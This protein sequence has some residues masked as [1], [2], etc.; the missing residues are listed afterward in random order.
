M[1]IRQLYNSL[2]P[3]DRAIY[4]SIRTDMRKIYL[5]AHTNIVGMDHWDNGDDAWLDLIDIKL[6]TLFDRAG[7]IESVQP[8]VNKEEEKTIEEK[9]E[10]RGNEITVKM[11]TEMSEASHK[12]KNGGEW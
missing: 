4:Q 1:D 11:D 2:S 10:V 5:N 6:A 7:K 3:E 9:V 8:I 12:L